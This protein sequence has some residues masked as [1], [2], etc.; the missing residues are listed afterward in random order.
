M[1]SFVLSDLL[2]A[3]LHVEGSSVE[4]RPSI[5][6]IV[7]NASSDVDDSLLKIGRF[8]AFNVVNGGLDKEDAPS[9]IY[10]IVASRELD[11]NLFVGD[12]A[13][14]ADSLVDSKAVETNTKVLDG[15]V[16]GDL[17]AESNALK[18]DVNSESPIEMEYCID[19]NVID[20]DLEADGSCVEVALV[21][22]D[23]LGDSPGVVNA[24]SEVLPSIAFKTLDGRKA[25]FNVLDARRNIGD[26]FG[27]MYLLVDVDIERHTEGSSV[28]VDSLAKSN[29]VYANIN[30]EYASI[31]VEPCVDLNMVDDGEAVKDAALVVADT[32]LR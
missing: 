25:V 29:L 31:K 7:I 16:E 1:D 10:P 30:E 21:D 17:I 23:M 19:S 20:A 15:P 11:T 24:S 28:D 4:A 27:A 32:L 8:V 9:E 26:A 13:A 5:E 22:F 12:S 6:C 18:F 3:G 14:G 2:N